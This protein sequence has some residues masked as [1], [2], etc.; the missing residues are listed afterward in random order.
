MSMLKNFC[1]GHS[2]GGKAALWAGPRMSALLLYSLI[3]PAYGLLYQE[4]N[5]EKTVTVI[6]TSFPIGLRTTIKKYN[7]NENALPV[8]QHS[9]LH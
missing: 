9:S 4:E 6:N 1:S 5:L 7:D 3:V 8:D 2:R